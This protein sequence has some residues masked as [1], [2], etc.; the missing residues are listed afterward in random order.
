V[1]KKKNIIKIEKALGEVLKRMPQD[2]ARSLNRA[3]RMLEGQISRNLCNGKL[4]ESSIA[5]VHDS[6]LESSDSSDTH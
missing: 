4:T 2:C 5:K 3:N 6:D 1:E